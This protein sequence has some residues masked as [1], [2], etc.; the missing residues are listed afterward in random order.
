MF[1][2]LGAT[3]EALDNEGVVTREAEREDMRSW[4]GL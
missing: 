1:A 2:L 3:E 4:K